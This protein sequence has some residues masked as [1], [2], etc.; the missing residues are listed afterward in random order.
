[1]T[2]APNTSRYAE[3]KQLLYKTQADPLTAEEKVERIRDNLQSLIKGDK[4][5]QRD[6]SQ[7]VRDAFATL[8]KRLTAIAQKKGGVK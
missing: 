3:L 4:H 1:M 7:E 8:N 2:N 6:N 5:G